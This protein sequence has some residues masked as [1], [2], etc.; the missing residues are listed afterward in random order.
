MDSLHTDLCILTAFHS[1]LLR[2]NVSEES[3]ADNRI[4]HFMSQ[5]FLYR[6]YI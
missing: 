5:L 2:R 3:Y 6:A 1:V 4:T